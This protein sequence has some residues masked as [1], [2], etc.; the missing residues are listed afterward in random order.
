MILN[1]SKSP[2]PIGILKLTKLLNLSIYPNTIYKV[3]QVNLKN[4]IL[5]FL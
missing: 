3:K 2:L 5:I 1:N 4:I